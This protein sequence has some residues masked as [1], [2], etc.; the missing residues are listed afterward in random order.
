[1]LLIRHYVGAS[2]LEGAGLFCADAIAEGTVIWRYD[3]PFLVKLSNAEL[4]ALPEPMREA[5]WKYSFRRRGAQRLHD[6]VYFCADDARFMNHSDT[7]NTRWRPET[8][9]Y[10]AATD[11]P[12]HTELTCDYRDF[13]EPDEIG[14]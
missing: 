1:M 14:F 11:L 4:Q 6:G 12:A 8:D 7:P 9:D 5:V 3:S 13:C 2:R 10:V